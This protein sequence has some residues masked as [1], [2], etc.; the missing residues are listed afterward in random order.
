MYNG[1]LSV[2]YDLEACEDPGS[3][4]FGRREGSSMVVGAALAFSCFPGYRLEGAQQL[5]CLG[6]AR[7]LWSNP[8]PRCVGRS[9]HSFC[10]CVHVC[11]CVATTHTKQFE[12]FCSTFSYSSCDLL[13]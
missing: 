3:P 5:L 13:K 8:L 6:G 4:L 10:H 1:T 11:D 9:S 7:R 12:Y 2:E